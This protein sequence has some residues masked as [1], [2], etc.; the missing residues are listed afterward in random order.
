MQ[1]GEA[2]V[3]AVFDPKQLAEIPEALRDK[4]RNETVHT[5]GPLLNE[6]SAVRN[7]NR[8]LIARLDDYTVMIQRAEEQKRWAF[9]NN[10]FDEKARLLERHENC[11]AD[12]SALNRQADAIFNTLDME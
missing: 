1:F 9:A 6:I 5:L 8:Q 11:I 3:A 7:A 2:N 4:I 10:L 12:L